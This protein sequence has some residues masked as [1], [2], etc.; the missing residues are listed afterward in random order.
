MSQLDTPVARPV[1]ASLTTEREL[2]PLVTHY[3]MP[4][5]VGVAYTFILAFESVFVSSPWK[6]PSVWGDL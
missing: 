2:G 6:M 5:L 1:E 4:V 3:G